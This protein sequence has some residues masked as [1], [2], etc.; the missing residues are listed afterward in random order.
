MSEERPKRASRT[1]EE[2]TGSDMWE[3]AALLGRLSVVHAD[4]ALRSCL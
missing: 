4:E 2:A 1:M 3:M